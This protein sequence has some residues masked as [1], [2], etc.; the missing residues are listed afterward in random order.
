MHVRFFSSASCAGKV[1]AACRDPSSAV[2]LN[3]LGGMAGNEN[4]LDVV[5]MDIEDQAS[6]ETAAEHVKSKY[7]VRHLLSHVHLCTQYAQG[8]DATPRPLYRS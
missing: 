3:G 2:D 7:G 1:V 8:V 4:R 6:L 5:R